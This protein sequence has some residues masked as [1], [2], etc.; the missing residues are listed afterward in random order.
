MHEAELVGHDRGLVEGVQQGI[1][2]GR[3]EGLVEGIVKGRQDLLVKLDTQRLGKPRRQTL[4]AL[5]K[6]QDEARLDELPLRLLEVKSWN[7]LL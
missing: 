7:E 1:A 5:A 3:V 2:R 6:I 4:A